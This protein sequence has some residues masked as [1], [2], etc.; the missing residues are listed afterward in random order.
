M[1]SGSPY[2]ERRPLRAPQEDGAAFVDPP[3]DEVP[4][5]LQ[6]NLRLRD[7]WSYD[8]Q[9]RSLS[10]LARESRRDLLDEARRWTSQ[11]RAVD[12]GRAGAKVS[13]FG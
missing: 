1:T 4:H 8:F 10:D 6:H 3:F 5:L 7:E 13:R 11:Y 12:P 2:L 9:G